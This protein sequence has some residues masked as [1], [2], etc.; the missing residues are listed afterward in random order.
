MDVESK[1]ITVLAE[2]PGKSNGMKFASLHYYNNMIWMIPWVE[3]NI[4]LYDISEK[5]MRKFEIPY[6]NAERFK[7]NVYRKSIVNGNY[8]WIL[9]SLYRCLFKIDMNNLSIEVISNFPKEVTFDERKSMMFKN[10]DIYGDVLYLFS[11]SC[12][13][14][15]CI[16]TFNNNISVWNN[17]FNG[18]FGARIDENITMLV[19]TKEGESISVI[20]DNGDELKYELPD[21][22]WKGA[23]LYSFWYSK[24]IGNKIYIYPHEANGVLKYYC[25]D[26]SLEIIN[27]SDAIIRNISEDE[28]ITVYD[29]YEKRWEYL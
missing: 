10:M 11:D 8:L 12:S 5:E 27:I 29:I 24:R 22:V 18:K 26:N 25:D 3:K 6:D 9:P 23:K 19:P 21:Y 2:Y 1:K 13:H 14:N 17:D 15:L 4:F 20:S 7:N 28:R 16:N